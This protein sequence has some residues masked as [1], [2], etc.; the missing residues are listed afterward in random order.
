MGVSSGQLIEAGVAQGLI[1]TEQLTE[2]KKMARQQKIPLLEAIATQ[3]RLPDIAFYQAWA[4]QQG[5]GF[6]SSQTLTTDMA[7]T[8]N[9]PPPLLIRKQL[10]PLTQ[11][12]LAMAD[13]SDQVCLQTLQ[14]LSGQTLTPVLVEADA[15]KLVLY[16]HF[17]QNPAWNE[18]K[19]DLDSVDLLD[20]IMRQAYLRRAS[21][22]HIEPQQNYLSIRFRID[23]SLQVYP[24]FLST[25]ESQSLISRIKVLANMD[26]AEQR[27]PQD[28]GFCY[29]SP[30]KFQADYDLRIATVPSHWGERLTIRLLGTQS[31]LISLEQLGFSANNQ[32]RFQQ[33]IQQPHGLIL[34]TGPT[35]SGKSTTLY[36]ALEYIKRPELNILTV[37]DP[38]EMVLSGISQVKAGTSILSFADVLRS[39]LRHDPD[40][41]MVGEIRDLE[42]AD[43]A[44]KAAM[45]GHLVFST[46]HTNTA[47]SA[48]TRLI[49]LG[50]DAFLVA[51][52]LIGVLAQ[53][54]VK[55][56]CS[57][58]KQP[59]QADEAQC[60]FLGVEFP[61]TLYQA[62][63]CLHCQG[64]GFYH[65]I[66][67][68][69]TLWLDD[70]LRQA[71]NQGQDELSFATIARQYQRLSQ[72]AKAKVLQGLTT[73]DEIKRVIGE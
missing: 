65:R 22:I 42:T 7:I 20:Q 15:I 32:Q 53:R 11:Q 21:D 27:L 4:V 18:V 47:M 1:T 16:Q 36:S 43:I 48:V 46:L 3:V 44:L 35:G 17:P 62:K 9:F 55:R 10:L 56:L 25:Q 73:L 57:H 52:T 14:R 33:A 8:D 19:Q 70:P 64:Q 2:L 61:Q 6:I 24:L 69:E 68:F 72:D 67:I 31:Q 38:I 66:G 54:L 13:P 71:I 58:C 12:R 60:E 26:I 40:I 23:G 28:G 50:C 49:N 5:I 30:Y 51:S 41:L 45:T 63:G 59:Y 29:Q 34:I 39:F 37:E